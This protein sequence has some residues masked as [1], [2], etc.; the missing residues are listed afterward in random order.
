MAR[1]RRTVHTDLKLYFWDI[2]G[3]ESWTQ[4]D[5]CAFFWAKEK[6][7]EGKS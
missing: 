1:V 4:A 5:F 3:D 6:R 7:I 2:A